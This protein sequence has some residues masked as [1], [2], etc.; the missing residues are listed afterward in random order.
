MTDTGYLQHGHAPGPYIT[1]S[2]PI[3]QDVWP[4]AHRWLARYPDRWRVVYV[5]VN[6]TFIRYKGEKITILIDGV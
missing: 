2:V 1:M 4:N 3:K 5:Q 6:R